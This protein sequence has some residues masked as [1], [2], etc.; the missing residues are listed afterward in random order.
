M[1][2]KRSSWTKKNR[3]AGGT[4]NGAG[5]G[6]RPRNS[7][8]GRDVDASEILAYTHKMA[9]RVDDEGLALF[10]NDPALGMANVISS[11]SGRPADQV[12]TEEAPEEVPVALFEPREAMMTGP[13]GGPYIE[14]QVQAA[15]DLGLKRFTGLA[16]V[17]D[18][19]PEWTLRRRTDR[20]GLELL[21]STGSIFS[22][23]ECTV[24]PA[25]VSAAVTNGYVLALYGPKLGVRPPT[26]GK[27]YPAT[28]RLRE[29]REARTEGLVAAGLVTWSS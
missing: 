27:P 22:R 18:A 1:S 11:V 17:L 21:D 5:D 13:P 4:G 26:P 12:L 9:H 14:G 7:I 29:F 25:W 15:V 2:K 28:Q 24:E 20:P 3:K 8:H 6:S 16:A 19:A 23:T 10:A